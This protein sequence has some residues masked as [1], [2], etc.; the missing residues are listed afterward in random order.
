MHFYRWSIVIRPLAALEFGLLMGIPLG[1]SKG[2]NQA[3]F[4]EYN[5]RQL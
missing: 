2:I 3:L 5:F 1:F 4:L